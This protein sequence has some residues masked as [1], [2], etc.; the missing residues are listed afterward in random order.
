MPLR[1]ARNLAELL[2]ASLQSAVYVL[3]VTYA[4]R[5]EVVLRYVDSTGVAG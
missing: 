4:A 2:A 3:E 5:G 1:E